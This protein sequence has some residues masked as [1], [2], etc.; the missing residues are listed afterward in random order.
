MMK[1][2]YIIIALITGI[3]FSS[4]QKQLEEKF[5]DPERTDQASIPAFFAS[6]LNNEKVKP[7]YYNV[8]TFLIQQPGIFSQTNTFSN[9]NTSY[10]HNDG[11]LGSFWKEFYHTNRDNDRDIT[12][13][14][15][16]ALY[17]LME[18]AYRENDASSMEQYNSFM[19]AGKIV[20][21]W[22]AAQMVD[23]WGDIP[24]SEAG[25]LQTNDVINN[26]KF[27]NQV[28]LYESFIADLTDAA[29]YF[30]TAEATQ[31]FTR[32]DIML[33][34]D[35]DRWRRFANSLKM[36][37]LMRMSFYDEP[38]AQQ[39]V[40]EMLNNPTDY[41]LI[42]GDNSSTY[43]PA[44]TDVLIHQL[45]DNVL[46]L[47]NALTE[48][49]EYSA[50]D[51][52]LNT[53]MLPA[54]DPRIPILFDK[55]GDLV[56]NKF[57]P[58]K[59]YKAMPVTTT[60][61]V[62]DRDWRLYS[63]WDTTTFLIN[64]QLPGI[65]MTASEVNYL[66]A[67]AEQRWGSA[68]K[69]KAAY[70]TGLRQSVTFYY[71]LHNTNTSREYPKE[72]SPSAEEVNAFIENPNVRLEGSATDKLAKIWTQKWAHF[73]FLQSPQAWSEYRR[74]KYPQLTFPTTGKLQG[75]S[76]PANRLV[77]PSVETAYNPH[78][79]EVRAKDTRDTKIFWDVK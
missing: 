55:F 49:R 3:V 35:T 22:H 23:M 25:S 40:M 50:P 31:A 15:A 48:G 58:N 54:E 60:Q 52:L 51:Y 74:T 68:D 36:R 42:D 9:S 7:Q 62:Q 1:K 29:T 67:E 59:E 53:L 24:Y 47:N 75:F 17:R 76:T 28:E 34:G 46:T 33:T 61:A 70:E 79:S 18:K 63:T 27:D 64:A 66:K 2:Y 32:Y 72:D 30:S 65:L 26:A 43:S 5:N 41:P 45:T 20:L 39:K 37:L 8:R 73:G 77:Y 13:N 14:G 57:I 44:T 16:M 12:L 71:Y 6:M 78:Y 4:C 11:Y 21:I 69:A 19:Q 38:T 56:D 10:Q